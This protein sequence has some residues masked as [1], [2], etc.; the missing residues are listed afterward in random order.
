MQ[1]TWAAAWRTVRFVSGGQ[2]ELVELVTVPSGEGD[3]ALPRNALDIP[4]LPQ[5]LGRALIAAAD[6]ADK[7]A[8]YGT[9]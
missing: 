2:R 1:G 3:P 8:G 9:E 6:E 4:V 7:M 5:L